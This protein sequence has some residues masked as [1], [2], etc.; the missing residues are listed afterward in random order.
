MYKFVKD[1]VTSAAG[2]KIV[3]KRGDANLPMS[4][5]RLVLEEELIGYLGSRIAFNEL[6]RDAGQ[7]NNIERIAWLNLQV[8]IER[9]RRAAGQSTPPRTTSPTTAATW[10]P[11]PAQPAP[12]ANRSGAAWTEEYG[13]LRKAAIG[14]KDSKRKSALVLKCLEMESKIIDDFSACP[15][16]MLRALFIS[17]NREPLLTALRARATREKD[18]LKKCELARL[19]RE[20]R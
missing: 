17:A 15:T 10:T 2:K 6:V 19:L 14:E 5:I 4:E 9:G 16:S 18:P 20:I 3:E 1:Q 11:S 8:G 7:M 12:A 13:A